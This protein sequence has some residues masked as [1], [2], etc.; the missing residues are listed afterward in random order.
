MGGEKQQAK[1]V[2]T[3]G[4]E[5]VYGGGFYPKLECKSYSK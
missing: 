3:Y 2:Y 4:Y 5:V 1:C